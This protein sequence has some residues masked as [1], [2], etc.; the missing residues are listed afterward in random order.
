[1]TQPQRP[2][3]PRRTI[4]SFVRRQG[5]LTPGQENALATLWPQYGIEL[6]AQQ[7]K[8][9]TLLEIARP[10]TLEIGFGN[11]ESLLEMAAAA[12]ERL[13]I[14][15][16]VHRPGVGHTLQGIE[17]HG[18]DNLYLICDDAVQVLQQQLAPASLDTVQLFFPDPWHKNRHHKRR[19]VQPAFVQLIAEKL[20]PG[21]LWHM[22]TDWEHYAQ[23]MLT[24]T[25]QNEDFENTAGSAR[26]A[27]RPAH[28]PLT[29]FEQRG[30]R[31]GHGVWDLIF[32]RR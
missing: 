28:R 4:R 21:G 30:E 7:D 6:P 11:G 13:F 23:H 20:K 10:V 27:S 26:F 2:N 22:A 25:E 12:K 29:K 24:V 15:I 32:R 9:D 1:M 18:L 5:R 3:A 16:E 14:G 8:L 19:I 31:L 17:R